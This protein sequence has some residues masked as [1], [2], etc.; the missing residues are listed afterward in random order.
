MKNELLSLSRHPTTH[1]TCFT[2]YITNGDRF[3]SESRE[4]NLQTQNSVVFVLDN[5]EA[6][7][8][9]AHKN[10]MNKVEDQLRILADLVMANQQPSMKSRAN[11]SSN[12]DEH[13]YVFSLSNIAPFF[14]FFVWALF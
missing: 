2:G 14:L 6:G 1:A 7:T 9:N 5:I 3:H 8:K 13:V 4:N 10:N 12:E 11:A